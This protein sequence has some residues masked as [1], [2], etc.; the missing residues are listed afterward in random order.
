MKQEIAIG[1]DIGG[2]NVEIG[3]IDNQGQIVEHHR[4]KTT[5]F[6]TAKELVDMVGQRI[7]EV[8][9]QLEDKKILGIGIGAPNGNYY[10]G[11]I[12]YAPNL[13]WDEVIPLAKMFEEKTGLPSKLTN[14]ANAAAYAEML[15]GDAQGMDDFLVVTL[16]TGLGSGIVVGGKV[17]HGYT[18][19]AGEL[20]HIVVSEED[21]PCG[22]G[23]NACLE[24]YA[25]AT[26]IVR[27]V[28]KM[29]EEKGI[30]KTP[31]LTAKQIYLSALE[32]D[33]ISLKAFEH[34][35]KVLG[36]SLTDY[37][38]LL[39]PEAIF[40]T[41]GLAKAHEILIPKINEVVD[42]HSLKIFKDTCKILP[43]AL[44]EQNAG[45]LGAAALITRESGLL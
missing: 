33:E 36:K 5:E 17:V 10:N 11:T 20:G 39:S 24:T 41:G 29:Q 42:K 37:I 27:T 22:C 15:Y 34:T 6:D 35:S 30:E 1:I 38:A 25:S 3:W 23:R 31:D 40:I 7:L 14:D 18:G 19:F 4:I 16:G 9:S 43:S 26:G 32:G 13:N 44:I 21:R 2:T 28:H 45:M 12:E 8:N